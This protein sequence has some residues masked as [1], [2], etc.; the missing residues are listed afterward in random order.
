M[1][2]LIPGTKIR[3]T[4]RLAERPFNGDEVVYAEVSDTGTI[5]RRDLVNIKEG[6]MVKSD[7]TGA[8]FGASDKEFEVLP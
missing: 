3:F 2:E 8:E 4:Q 7:K 6:Y 5:I 1:S